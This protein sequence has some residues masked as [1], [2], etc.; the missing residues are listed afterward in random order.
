MSKFEVF[1]SAGE[2]SGDIS[3]SEVIRELRKMGI[4]CSGVGGKMMEEAGMLN[5]TKT[6][7]SVYSSVGFLESFKYVFPKLILLKK[8]LSYLRKTKPNLVFLVDNQGFN[9]PLAK[10][11]KKMGLSVFYYFPPMVSV[12]DE[13]VKY[14]ISK[15]CD[16]I[17]CTFE[18][19]YKIYKEVSSNAI[20]VGNPLVDRVR[21][22]YSSL[23]SYLKFFDSNKKRIL[24]LPGSR[25]QEVK[26]LLLPMLKVAKLVLDGET[27]LPKDGFEFYLIISHP[28][29]RDYIHS[30]IRD[31]G[32]WGRIKIFDQN[33]D[34]ALYDLCDLA[35]ASSGTVTLELALLEKPVIVIYKVSKITFE[36]GKRLVK[37]KFV[38]LP[39]ILLGSSVYPE[40]LQEDVNPTM[41]LKHIENL[42]DKDTIENIRNNLRKIKD[43]YEPGTIERVI[44]EIKS[45]LVP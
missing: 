5:I 11:C 27:N 38:S 10:L 33:R 18:E 2:V 1:F 24:L 39:N 19:D 15:Y 8:I 31:V 17:L 3:A 44:E 36:I 40:L 4:T 32:L 30:K 28:I 35:I 26:T 25:E 45:C 7:E 12:W 14:K 16:R 6:D 21:K 29:F 9:I 22:S 42:L 41:I 43:K 37:S 34:Y 13:N 20:F 23:E